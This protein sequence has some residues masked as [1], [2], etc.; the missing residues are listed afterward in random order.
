L[1][2]GLAAHEGEVTFDYLPRAPCCSTMYPANQGE[3]RERARRYTEQMIHQTVPRWLSALIRR[4]PGAAQRRL[5]D[6]VQAYYG[7][8]RAVACRVTT[9]SHVIDQY[10]IERI[11]LLKIDAERAELDILRGIEARHWPLIRQMVL[12]VHYPRG[13]QYQELV[14]LLEGHRFRITQGSSPTNEDSQMFFLRRD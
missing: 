8:S 12:E 1:P 11:D 9:L 13:P 5:V 6:V 4:T 10:Q 14:E 3:D 7:R 2:L